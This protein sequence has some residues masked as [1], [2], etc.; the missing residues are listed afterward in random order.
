MGAFKVTPVV[1]DTNVLIS[2]LL[3][4][5]TPGKLIELWKKG[6]IRPIV[7]REVID[8]YLRVLAYPKFRLT[9]DE[10]GYL[11][12]REILPHFKIVIAGQGKSIVTVDPSDDKFIWCALAGKAEYIITSDKHMLSI[13]SHQ[14]ISILTPTAFLKSLS[15]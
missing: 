4:G 11:L 6:T 14:G 12:F 10:I 5:G 1:V 7:S 3:F 2:A 13:K 9:E 15:G 8:E